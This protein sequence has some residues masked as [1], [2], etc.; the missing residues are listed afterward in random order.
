MTHLTIPLFPITQVWR[1]LKNRIIPKVESFLV[2]EKTDKS[3][4]KIKCLRSSVALATMKLFQKLPLKTFEAKLPQLITVVCIALKNKESNERDIARE[5]LAKMA[6]SL[7]M[8]YLPLILSELSVSLSEGYKLHVRSATLHSILVAIAN[9]YEQSTVNTVEEAVALPFDRCVVAML[10]LIHQDIFGKASEIKEVEHVDK[11]LIKEAMGSK[12]QD[13]LEIIARLVL[14][15][16]SIASTSVKDKHPELTNASVVHS[17]VTP[18]LERLNDPEVLPSTIRKVKECLNRVAVG[19]SS[20]GRAKYE[21]VLPFVYATVSPFVLGKVKHLHDADADLEDSD[22]E[23]EAPIQ[24]SKTNNGVS[25]NG[26]CAKKKVAPGNVVAV[27]TWN[28]SSLGSATNQN[29][30]LGMKKQ[31]KRDLHKVID[32]AA[33][34][35]LTG[36]SRHSPMKSSAAKSMNNPANACA[37]NFGLALLSSCLKRSKIDV[38]DEVLCSM[39]DPYLHLLTQCVRFSSDSNALTLSLRCLCVFLR[40]DLPSVAKSV[41][42]LGPSLLDHL[43]AAGAAT[44]TQS[45]IVQGCFKTLT[46]L[47][48]HQKFASKPEQQMS[49]DFAVSAETFKHDDV[50]PLSEVQMQALV[51]LLQSAVRESDHHNSTFVLIKAIAAKK[52][53]S[54]EFYDLMEIIL[55]LSVQSQKAS[56]RLVG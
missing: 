38:S 28:P 6:V 21:E 43:T 12:S 39:A 14:F 24:I 29:S 8:K 1:S 44:N 40:M 11:R 18:F 48:S 54:A 2:R 10:D 42:K 52:Y 27:T 15:Q 13:S 31:Q 45:E 37:V 30:A 49:V 56:I 26:G 35:K 4:K 19:F 23:V 17:I 36:S 20:N 5:T 55:K 50:L 25:R 7:D 47:L 3:G 16:P 32:G 22:D 46:L 53:I 33:A 34:P 9:V 41:K 51:S